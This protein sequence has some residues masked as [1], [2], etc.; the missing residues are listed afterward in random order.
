MRKNK[1][2]GQSTADKMS[3]YSEE[4]IQK[5]IRMA[6]MELEQEAIRS[7]RMNRRSRV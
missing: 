5:R 2:D 4:E 7:D 1:G 6:E 3:R